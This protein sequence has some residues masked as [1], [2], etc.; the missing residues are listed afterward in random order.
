VLFGAG[1]AY[2][3]EQLDVSLKTPDDME[4]KLEVPFLGLLPQLG[5]G[6]ES[7][8][9]YSYYRKRAKK[10]VDEAHKAL[11]EATAAFNTKKNFA[12][13]LQQ[14]AAPLQAAAASLTSAAPGTGTVPARGT[15]PVATPQKE[16]HGGSLLGAAVY[17]TPGRWS[18][19]DSSS[20]R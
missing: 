13:T 3:R 17:E 1:F 12:D 4:T 19:S 9:Y 18:S 8:G 7:G 15:G 5:D 2:L 10:K 6:A 20:W 11:N 14:A 16:G